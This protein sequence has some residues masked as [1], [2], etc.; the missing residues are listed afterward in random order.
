MRGVVPRHLGLLCPWPPW[1]SIQKR[2]VD[3]QPQLYPSLN[4]ARFALVYARPTHKLDSFPFPVHCL[5]LRCHQKCLKIRFSFL[6]WSV[7]RHQKSNLTSELMVCACPMTIRWSVRGFVRRAAA[8]GLLFSRRR[9][10]G[11][12]L[13]ACG[14]PL[15]GLEILG[16]TEEKNRCKNKQWRYKTKIV[17]DIFAILFSFLL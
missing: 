10:E 8:Y 6:K 13:R 17:L 1:R 4:S 3:A 12:V 5:T 15:C 11:G 2:A 14:W 16:A 9:A 7:N